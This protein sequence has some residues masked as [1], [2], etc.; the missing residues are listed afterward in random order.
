[1]V[2]SFCR[3]RKHLLGEREGREPSP[4]E[5]HTCPALLRMQVREAGLLLSTPALW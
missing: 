2:P 1:M 3:R 5:T 4:G